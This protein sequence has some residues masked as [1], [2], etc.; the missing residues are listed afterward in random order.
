MKA[1]DRISRREMLRR[2]G[3][4]LAGLGASS[5]LTPLFADADKRRFQIGACDWSIG[6][7]ADPAAFTVAKAI[8]LDGVQVS[9]GTAGNNMHL[10]QAEV[11]KAYR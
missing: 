1:F 8:G 11:Q 4:S 6:K 5:P 2:A 7:M 9:L 3:M 10:R